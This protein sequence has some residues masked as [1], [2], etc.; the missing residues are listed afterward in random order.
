VSRSIKPTDLARVIINGTEWNMGTDA[1]RPVKDK[2]YFQARQLA[3]DGY[4]YLVPRF[5]AEGRAAER[6][7]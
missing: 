3:R 4:G 5:Y 7:K 1:R 2:L 6:R